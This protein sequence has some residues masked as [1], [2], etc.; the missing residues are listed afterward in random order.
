MRKS[1]F[2]AAGRRLFTIIRF[3]QYLFFFLFFIIRQLRGAGANDGGPIVSR[4]LTHSRGNW[5]LPF[6]FDR[7]LGN[8]H[9]SIIIDLG[10]HL[11]MAFSH[12]K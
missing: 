6:P 3:L 12:E 5:R 9:S 2:D 11:R 7:I 1:D 4:E 10:P 8:P